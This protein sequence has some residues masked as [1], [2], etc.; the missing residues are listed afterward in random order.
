MR[1]LLPFYHQRT[2]YTC[3]PAALQIVFEYFSVHV[4]Q[5]RL[6]KEARTNAL[7]GTDH[8]HMI[9]AATDHDFFCYVNDDADFDEVVG[10]L[11]KKLPVIV[12]FIEPSDNEGHYA[13][14]AGVEGKTLIL[15]DPWNGKGFRMDQEEF[16]KRWHDGNNVHKQWLMV[17]ALKKFSLGKQYLPR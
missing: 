9:K 14:V 15:H 17:L 8:E 16:M 13:V 12:H 1:L 6:A 2:G 10:F 3:G 11:K 5:T 4:S 7:T